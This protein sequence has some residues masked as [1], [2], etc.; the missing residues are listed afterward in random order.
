M[1]PSKCQRVLAF[2]EEHIFASKRAVDVSN[3]VI[4]FSA[5]RMTASQVVIKA[6]EAREERLRLRLLK[7]A[8]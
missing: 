8:A 1:R 6:T 3:E 7:K 5:D 2:T 4:G